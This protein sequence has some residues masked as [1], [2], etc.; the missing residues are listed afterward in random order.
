MHSNSFVK[1]LYPYDPSKD[2][3]LPCKDIGLAFNM[4]DILQILNTQ[5]PNWWQARK[6]GTRG[7]AGLIP[8]QELEE[9]RRAFV[10][11]EFDYAT[12]TSKCVGCATVRANGGANG[13]PCLPFQNCERNGFS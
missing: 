9:R 5:D 1:A 2:T 4:G 8:S 6:V 7:H 11:A 3:L 12:T 13:R 10:P